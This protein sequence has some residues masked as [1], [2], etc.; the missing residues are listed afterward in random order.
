[1]KSGVTYYRARFSNHWARPCSILS[2]GEIAIYQASK[3]KWLNAEIV[4]LKGEIEKLPALPTLRAEKEELCHE[5][6]KQKFALQT[7]AKHERA[8][9]SSR[10]LTNYCRPETLR[11]GRTHVGW[12]TFYFLGSVT[13]NVVDYLK[14]T[15]ERIK[16]PRPK[17][18]AFKL[19]DKRL[20][21]LQLAAQVDELAK[22]ALHRLR[23]DGSLARDARPLM[24]WL[25]L[26]GHPS[27]RQLMDFDRVTQ[28]V[29]K[30]LKQRIS[31]EKA[32]AKREAA[33]RRQRARRQRGAAGFV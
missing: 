15:G 11:N 19:L 21:S 23:E 5:I 25:A 8:K 26:I 33:A 6:E 24:W 2:P 13:G 12:P 7:L 20:P 27:A 10:I 9:L 32:Q 22:R 16:P 18:K 28:G 4:R 29:V 31:E 17:W 14:F 1:M 30:R 3:E